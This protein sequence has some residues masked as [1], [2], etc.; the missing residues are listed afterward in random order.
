MTENSLVLA[1]ASPRRRELIERLH[2]PFVC[3]ESG[4]EEECAEGLSVSAQELPV[5][6]ARGKARAAALACQKQE[7]TRAAIVIGAD[8]V[9]ICNG[10]V[11][12]KPHSE[13]EAAQMLR[14]LAG[15]THEVV[16]GVALCYAP[17][18]D[19][20]GADASKERKQ[21]TQVA[22]PWLEEAFSVRTEVCFYPMSE[23]EIS[24]YIATGEP[25]DKAGAYGIQGE[26]ALFVKEIHGDFY[27]VMGLPI[28]A[29]ARK[30]AA[31]EEQIAAR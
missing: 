22:E 9:V 16:T 10:K 31:F 27:N 26:G 29:L 18:N 2:R 13:A 23:A 5:L 3:V 25:M 20:G 24:A 15:R 11:L 30:L 4:Y 17:K 1:S 7:A 6:F 12:G 21:G 8:T 28:A 14:S 19:E